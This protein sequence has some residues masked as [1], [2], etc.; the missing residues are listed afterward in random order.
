MAIVFWGANLVELHLEKKKK[1]KKPER[2]G[3]KISEETKRKDRG[4]ISMW[5]AKNPTKKAE[6]LKRYR[7]Y[8]QQPYKV[9]SFHL[10][11]SS[12]SLNIPSINLLSSYVTENHTTS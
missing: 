4:V 5:H 7:Q 10:I 9:L 2:Q 11:S 12:F 3:D 8:L 1:K 6:G